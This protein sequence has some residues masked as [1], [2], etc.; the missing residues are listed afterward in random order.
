M[1]DKSSFFNVEQKTLPAE[2]AVP[3]C[4][5]T[6]QQE[7]NVLRYEIE[8]KNLKIAFLEEELKK[9]NATVSH[10]EEVV[11]KT[12]EAFFSLRRIRELIAVTHN[13]L[14]Y[15]SG[16]IE[17][18]TVDTVERFG[19]LL[20]QID[21][22]VGETTDIVGSIKKRLSLNIVKQESEAAPQNNMQLIRQQYETVI[23]GILN[24]LLIII[25]IKN[26]DITKLDKIRERVQDISI[27]SSDI[28]NF[29]MTT[30]ILSLNASIESARAGRYGKAFGVVAQEVKRLAVNS[31][32]SAEKIQDTLDHTAIFIDQAVLSIKETADAEKNFIN[33]TIFLLKDFF[34]SIIDS[35]IQLSSVMDGT[36]GNTSTS[37]AEI[38]NIVINLQFE[39]ITRQISTHIAQTLRDVYNA[40]CELKIN[41]FLDEKEINEELKTKILSHYDNLATMKQEREIAALTLKT[42]TPS[43]DLEA[44]STSFPTA[45]VEEADDVTFF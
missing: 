16:K 22:T 6:D 3:L 27:F 18:A 32:H 4:E 8:Q 13:Q 30:K 43:G 39:D 42:T 38:Q 15:T 45:S 34:L 14:K 41:K 12:I 5:G 7:L 21:R 17:E 25:D 1:Y 40:L 23:Q 31:T 44:D 37:R 2:N 9:K 10:L 36:L 11:D 35:L 20:S 26:E 28:S 19:R 33:S 24:E 29:A